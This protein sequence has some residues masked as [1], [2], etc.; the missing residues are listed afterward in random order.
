MSLLYLTA[1][2]VNASCVN[3]TELKG[4]TIQ[5]FIMQLACFIST[6]LS[7]T[8]ICIVYWKPVCGRD[9]NMQQYSDQEL[10]HESERV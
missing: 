1:P 8:M 4:I 3:I 9:N 10:Q 5:S 7:T 2:I 6:L